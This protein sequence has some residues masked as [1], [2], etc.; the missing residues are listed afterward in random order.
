MKPLWQQKKTWR[1]TWN[2]T[3]QLMWENVAGKQPLH[4]VLSKSVA[5]ISETIVILLVHNLSQQKRTVK[6]FSLIFIA[7]W[8]FFVSILA[9]KPSTVEERSDA[10]VKKLEVLDQRLASKVTFCLFLLVWLNWYNNVFCNVKCWFNDELIYFRH[11]NLNLWSE[12][13]ELK[14]R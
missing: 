7:K 5:V 14:Y 9:R 2:M 1:L 13:M 4:I 3:K 6:I 10:I 12:V 8:Y 11:S